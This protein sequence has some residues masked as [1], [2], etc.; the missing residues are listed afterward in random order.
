MYSM[1]DLLDLNFCSSLFPFFVPSS[2]RWCVLLLWSAS[3]LVVLPLSTPPLRF[4]CICRKWAKSLSTLFWCF[5]FSSVLRRS[6][7]L[8]IAPIYSTLVAHLLIGILVAARY[9]FRYACF[10]YRDALVCLGVPAGRKCLK[11]TFMFVVTCSKLVCLSS[12]PPVVLNFQ[13]VLYHWP[14]VKTCLYY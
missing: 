11:Q 1:C 8:L 3:I 12:N 9:A 2:A 10:F 13:T 4:C 14:F 7:F 5:V 6:F